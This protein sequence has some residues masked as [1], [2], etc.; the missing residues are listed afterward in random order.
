MENWRCNRLILQGLFLGLIFLSSIPIVVVIFSR[1]YDDR[2]ETR[3]VRIEYDAK[4]NPFYT[5]YSELDASP[6]PWNYGGPSNNVATPRVAKKSGNKI[7]K[8][9]WTSVHGKNEAEAYHFISAYLDDRPDAKLRPAVVVV[10]YFSRTA[11]PTNLYCKLKFSDGR[12]VCLKQKAIQGKSNC[13]SV[14]DKK[15]SQPTLYICRLRRLTSVLPVSVQ[16]SNVSN[17][18]PRSSSDEIPVGNLEHRKNHWHSKKKFG[19]FLGGPL[20]FKENMIANLTRFIQMSQV[21]GAEVFT[22][23]VNPELSG[24]NAI[25][26]LMKTYPDTV[27]LIE[28]KKFEMHRPLHYYGQLV[29]ITDC[30]YRS[31]YEVDY[32]VMMDMDEMILPMHQNS[33]AELV[34]ALEKQ[35]RYASYSFLNRFFAPL[36]HLNTIIDYNSTTALDTEMAAFDENAVEGKF[37]GYFK[38]GD[39]PVYF[40]RTQEVEC[41]FGHGAKTK[42]FINPRRLVRLT[43]HEA[44]ESVWQYKKV[45][46]VPANVAIS[47]HYRDVTIPD[48]VSKPLVEN[49]IALKFAKPFV[50]LFS[51]TT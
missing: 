2:S 9:H 14:V 45:Y 7:E 16:I 21:M 25:D 51:N 3:A 40:S 31:M 28:W 19:V 47:A 24:Q 49:T 4:N 20:V 37:S 43:V 12:S 22:M 46:Q 17:C 38:D 27:R 39:V 32:L 50:E 34:K 5:Y 36:P 13:D 11:K 42:L 41:Y 44:C 6:L 26:F 33:W 35:G 15:K 23:Y 29:L 1:Y 48:C 30:L 8:L 10:G 18:D